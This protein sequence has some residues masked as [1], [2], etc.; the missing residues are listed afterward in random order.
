MTPHQIMM[1]YLAARSALWNAHMKPLE[2]I[3]RGGDLVDALQDV[4]RLLFRYL[5][6]DP[7]QIVSLSADFSLGSAPVREILIQPKWPKS[8]ALVRGGEDKRQWLNSTLERDAVTAIH[9]VDF[10]QWDQA[11][12]F[13]PDGVEGIAVGVGRTGEYPVVLELRDID[14]VSAPSTAFGG[15][16]HEPGIRN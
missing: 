4:D 9:F 3:V 10:F 2:A 7:L 13:Y 15:R 5:V 16:D 14:F 1:N 8:S 12:Y 11:G 6:A